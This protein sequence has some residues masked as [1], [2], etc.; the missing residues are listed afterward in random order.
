MT[1]PGGPRR[2]FKATVRNPVSP[3]RVD[4]Y[5]PGYLVISGNVIEE[6][7]G[8]DPR[9][10]LGPVEYIDLSNQTIVPGFV[11]THVHLPQFLIMGVGVGELLS[12]LTNYTYPEE[13]RFADPRH[14]ADVAVRFFDAM[15]ANGTT[16]AVVYSSVHEEA[17]DI[18]FTAARA[19]GVRAFIGKAMMDQNVPETLLERSDKSIEASVRLFEKWDGADGGRLRYVFTPRF[20]ASCSMSLMKEVGKIAQER[21]AFIQSHLSENIDE[22]SWVRS[23]FP[24][25]PSYAG[26]YDAAGILGERSIMAHCIHLSADEISLLA[27]RHTKVA[28]CPYSNR[29]LRSGTMPYSTLR[30]AG[31]KIGLGSDIAGGPSLSMMDQIDQ[32]ADAVDISETEA[33]Y[34]ATLGGARIVGLEHWIGSLDPGKDADFVILDGRTVREVYLRGKRVYF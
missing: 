20:A 19:K 8:V 23:L 2:I 1:T 7:T 18:A 13:A 22:I 32:A 10:R 5:S 6:L 25:L 28:F 21:G 24:D 9:P 30:G 34:L 14:A 29:T 33:F 26:I 17:T 31:L 4:T 27:R 16:T 3:D 12:W 15:V 11:D